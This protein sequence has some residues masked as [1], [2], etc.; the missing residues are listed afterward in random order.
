MIRYKTDSSVKIYHLLYCVKI[1]ES[2]ELRKRL[3]LQDC[4]DS[5]KKLRSLTSLCPKTR[6][7]QTINF[8]PCQMT[9][10]HLLSRQ[11]M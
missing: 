5:S 4:E 1:E 11:G 6:L 8:H 2:L 3:I 9:P 10:F 7:D